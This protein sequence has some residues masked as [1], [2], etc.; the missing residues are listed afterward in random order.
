MGKCRGVIQ[1]DPYIIIPSKKFITSPIFL[2][3]LSVYSIIYNLSSTKKWRVVMNEN[4]RQLWWE[5]IIDNLWGLF[6]F[7]VFVVTSMLIELL[8]RSAEQFGLLFS[9]LI[10]I[11]GWIMSLSGAICCAGLVIR[12][13]CDFIKYLRGKCPPDVGNVSQDL[14]GSNGED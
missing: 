11:V 4:L 1:P 12:N 5:C 10:R 6:L 9:L 14:G 2:D 7:F 8:A 3:I 13:T